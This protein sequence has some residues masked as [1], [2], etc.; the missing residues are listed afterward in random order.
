MVFLKTFVDLG[1]NYLH[2]IQLHLIQIFKWYLQTLTSS[3]NRTQAIKVVKI[4][5]F[6]WNEGWVILH[7]IIGID[8]EVLILGSCVL[9]SV[10]QSVSG[11]IT[12]PAALSPSGELVVIHCNACRCYLAVFSLELNT[13]SLCPFCFLNVQLERTSLASPVIW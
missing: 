10:E 9:G 1:Y 8:A 5:F 6:F 11:L 13:S 2:K 7:Y 3:T 4:I 12:E